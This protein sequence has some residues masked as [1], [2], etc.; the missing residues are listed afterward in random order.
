VQSPGQLLPSAEIG[1]AQQSNTLDF[2]WKE[3]DF[4][5]HCM[6]LFANG[7]KEFP[8]TGDNRRDILLTTKQIE[9]LFQCVQQI[10]FHDLDMEYERR[11]AMAD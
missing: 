1:T 6:E 9:D 4:I 11:I 10:K 3:A 7:D 8:F 2:N 5:M